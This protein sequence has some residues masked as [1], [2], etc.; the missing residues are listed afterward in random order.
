[1]HRSIRTFATADWPA[2]KRIYEA[3]LATG[4]A[5]FETEAPSYENWAD[6]TE[7]ACRLVLEE[8]QQ[9]IG[10]C[11]VSAVSSRQVYKG[12][13][14]VSV[15]VDPAHKGKGIG[16]ALLQ[17]LICASEAQGFW[18]LQASIFPENH[19]SLQ[20]HLKNGFREVGRR[21]R[22]GQRAGVWRDTIL[23]ERRS[24]VNGWA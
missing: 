13:G 12:V 21:E 17:A 20:L 18:T 10:W 5:S 16:M 19:A 7:S 3:G 24:Q 4:L 22:I 11:K 8:G 6:Q 23:L 14:E 2:V 1:M 9:I 15:Y